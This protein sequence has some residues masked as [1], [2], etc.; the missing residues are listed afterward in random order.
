MILVLNDDGWFVNV[1]NDLGE[2]VSTLENTHNLRACAS[3]GCAIHNHPSVHALDSAPLNWR[4]DRGI[5][6]RICTH[7]IGH[8]DYDSALYLQSIGRD[9]KNVHGCDGCCGPAK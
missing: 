4:E 3:R 8:P 9:S 5:L 2:I 6:E 7:G 1:V